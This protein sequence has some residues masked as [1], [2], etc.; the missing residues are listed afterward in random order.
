M[1][2][3][4]ETFLSYMAINN[5]THST[6]SKDADD[7]DSFVLEYINEADIDSLGLLPH[8]SSTMNVP[9]TDHDLFELCSSSMDSERTNPQT[10]ENNDANLVRA[11]TASPSPEMD[12]SDKENWTAQ[13][14]STHF[15]GPK[16]I[17]RT[18]L[19]TIALAELDSL[20][21]W[22]KE[23]EEFAEW[24][25]PVQETGPTVEPTSTAGA[26][27]EGTAPDAPCCPPQ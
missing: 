2:A 4:Y 21:E 26:P 27:I 14:S 22:K 13:P 18:A 19:A 5:V 10:T 8:L 1:E 7:Y 15:P 25:E 6:T 16:F 11:A 20:G 23:A 24:W 3:S 9:P 17:K 12:F